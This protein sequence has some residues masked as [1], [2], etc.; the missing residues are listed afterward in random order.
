MGAC[1]SCLFGSYLLRK[2]ETKV[3]SNG[4]TGTPRLNKLEHKQSF[5][6][7]DACGETAVNDK[8]EPA[9]SIES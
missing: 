4:G 1:C 2:E 8:V 5:I 6:V 7:S 3:M 9:E